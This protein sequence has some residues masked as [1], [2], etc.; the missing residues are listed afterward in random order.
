MRHAL[1]S[2]FIRNESGTLAVWAAAAAFPLMAAITFSIDMQSLRNQRAAL[3]SAVDSAVLAAALDGSI[4]DSKR[5]DYAI[6]T[7]YSNYEGNADGVVTAKA[8]SDKNGVELF[9]EA[10]FQDSLSIAIGLS[11]SVVQAHGRAD[12]TDE[13]TICVLALNET[14]PD[15]IRFD[16]DI[17]FTAPTCSVHAN[18]RHSSAI[19]STTSG[20]PRAKGFCA[21]GGIRGYTSP[22]AKADCRPIADPYADL[23]APVPGACMPDFN[24]TTVSFPT[25]EGGTENPMGGMMAAAQSFDPDTENRLRG[26]LTSD[27]SVNIVLDNVVMTPG[28]YCGGLTI[29][30]RNVSFLPGQYIMLDGPLVVKDDAD[31]TATESII[32][33]AGQRAHLKVEDRGAI[34]ITAP[35]T[36]A[37]GSIAIMEDTPLTQGQPK[38]RIRDG[39]ISVTGTVYLPNHHLEIRGDN[40]NVGA[41]APATSF[42]VDTARFRGSGTIAVAVDHVAAGIPAIQPR[43][44]EGVRLVE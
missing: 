14:D 41:S 25:S 29:A 12:T 20:T 5:E 42:I 40:S 23:P 31:V 4:S 19:R 8:I 2:R 26:I 37:H 21:V 16:E 30:G 9:V 13:D 34:K 11:N 6:S 3:D 17:S 18:S 35:K 32:S 44:D 28:T 33:L 22:A 24:F 36:G 15:A 39:A 38:S 27:D 1:I 10:K 43:S 7:F